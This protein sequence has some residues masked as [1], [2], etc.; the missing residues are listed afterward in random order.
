MRLNAHQSSEELIAT[1]L[2]PM[3]QRLTEAVD[4]LNDNAQ[5]QARSAEVNM[6]HAQGVV[7]AM[8]ELLQEIQATKRGL[9]PRALD[10][11]TPRSHGNPR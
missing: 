4:T 10:F 7:V 2:V 5:A 8:K 11:I 3:I 9:I 6:R 1:E